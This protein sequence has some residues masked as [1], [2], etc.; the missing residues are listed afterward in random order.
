VGLKLRQKLSGIFD[1]ARM[2]CGAEGIAQTENGANG[3]VAQ[4][5]CRT[6]GMLR[7]CKVAQ[8]VML[9]RMS[10]RRNAA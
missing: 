4:I 5:G 3:G 1:V 8:M 2:R 6:D 7:K 9:R 10:H